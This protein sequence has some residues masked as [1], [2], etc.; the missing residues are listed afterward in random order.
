MDISVGGISDVDVK[1]WRIVTVLLVVVVNV[2]VVGNV[3]VD[4]MR[5]LQE[6]CNGCSLLIINQNPFR[7]MTSFVLNVN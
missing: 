2:V 5:L 3:E 7:V 4:S 1:Y 6:T